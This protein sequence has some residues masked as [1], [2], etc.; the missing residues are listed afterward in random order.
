MGTLLDDFLEIDAIIEG[1]IFYG[2]ADHMF[3][4]VTETASFWETRASWHQVHKQGLHTLQTS[5]WDIWSDT[6]SVKTQT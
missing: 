1:I 2:F 5:A 6:S 4:S 3:L